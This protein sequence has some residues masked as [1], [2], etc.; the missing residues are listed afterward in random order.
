MDPVTLHVRGSGGAEFEMDVPP[1]G[2]HERESFLQRLAAGDIVALDPDGDPIDR[3]ALLAELAPGDADLDG[4]GG[5]DLDKATVKELR[6][7]A[8]DHDIDLGEVSKK[9]EILEVIRAADD[10]D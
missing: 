7:F 2:T 4:V 8:E 1:E 6:A 5:L 9:A 3:L 10:D